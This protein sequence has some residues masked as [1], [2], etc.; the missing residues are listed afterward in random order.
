VTSS[1]VA[2]IEPKLLQAEMD[3]AKRKPTKNLDAYDY[4]LRGAAK[5]FQWTREATTEAMR[6]Y[7]KAI[8]LDR[9]Y[10]VAHALAATCYAWRKVN[11]W[12]TDSARETAEAARLARR[13]IELGKDDAFTL[14]WAGWAL[15]Y[16]AH[17]LDEGAAS[18][19]R[20][21][22]LNPNLAAA[23][24]LNGLMRIFL[25]EP[26]VAITQITRAIRLSAVSTGRR[27]LAGSMF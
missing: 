8:E 11:G 4:V 17:E 7:Y 1:V 12:M 13:A 24:Y 21:L 18:I 22:V 27:T 19:D 15:A 10:A 26:E 23:W 16:V 3:R 25:G 6:L 20:A 2:A 5:T 14:A 9:D